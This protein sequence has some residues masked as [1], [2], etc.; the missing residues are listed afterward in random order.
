MLAPQGVDLANNVAEQGVDCRL[1]LRSE[2]FVAGKWIGA[3]TRIAV[4][5]PSDDSVIGHVPSLNE[6]IV[7]VAIEAARKAWPAWR[8]KTTKERATIL[9]RWSV[10]IR[11]N[12]DRLAR[13]I[14]AEQGKPL[15]EARAE[16]DYAQSFIDWFAAEAQRQR[17]A[18]IPSHIGNARLFSLREP[19][20]VVAAVTPWNFPSAMVTRKAAA[21]M[22]AGCPVIVV[23]SM[24]TPFSALALAELAEAA[25]VPPGIFSVLTGDNEKT[26]ATLCSSLDVRALSF[27]GST[28]VGRLLMK[29]AAETIKKVSLE[30]GG[31]APFIV[32]ADADINA[33]VTACV[34]A[35]FTTSGQD[36]LGV[37]RVFVH[38]GVYE[39]FAER[40][41]AASAEL[42]VGP[43]TRDEVDLGP[44]INAAAVLKCERHIA[45][46]LAKG[47]D[48]LLAGGIREVGRRFFYPAVLGNVNKSMSI[49]REE[50]FGPVAPLI[51]F[52]DVAEL[53]EAANDT[54]YGLA[55]YVFSRNATV[56]WQLAEL[57]EFGMVALNTAKMTGPPVPFG[58]YKQSGLGREGSS[59][60]LDEFS[61]IKYVC[62][63]QEEL[64]DTNEA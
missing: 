54:I 20:G 32:M 63:N 41:V 8:R 46:A 28:Q 61:E 15:V 45:D 29:Q 10:L 37:N 60:G 64:I 4:T 7:D 52:S 36:C 34:Q 13:I 48:L 9:G 31:H 57:L 6:Q 14:T 51:A 26:V 30:L 50:T 35:K 22:A 58:G 53:V 1:G 11:E 39:K 2:A 44:L 23:P 16:V 40:F 47:A 24:L 3:E 38:R 42:T 5:D 25:G 18:V 27:T 59:V 49:Y 12:R 56:A 21:A 33:A 17:G 62:W 43:G 19:V 55:A